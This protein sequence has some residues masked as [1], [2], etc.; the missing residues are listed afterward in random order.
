MRGW[1]FRFSVNDQQMAGYLSAQALARGHQRLGI[2]LVWLLALSIR[3]LSPSDYKM[4]T[5]NPRGVL[6]LA[7]P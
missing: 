4:A 6:V 3:A 5:F 1:S 7:Q 2:V